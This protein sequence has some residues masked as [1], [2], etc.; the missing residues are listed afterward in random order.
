MCIRDRSKW[1]YGQKKIRN[2]LLKKYGQRFSEAMAD[3]FHGD[4][5]YP[6]NIKKKITQKVKELI[7]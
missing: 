6:T 4:R 7:R 5:S 2:I 3:V 1:F